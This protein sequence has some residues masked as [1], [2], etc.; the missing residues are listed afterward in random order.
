MKQDFDII[1]SAKNLTLLY[2]TR[3]GIFNRFEHIA[4]NDISFDLY[5]GETIGVLGRNGSGKSSL[6]R[7]LAG[8]IPPTHGKVECDSKI[9]RSLLTLG[10]GFSPHLS[11]RNNA[12]LSAMLQG[13]NKREASAALEEINDFAELGKF[14][15][16]PVKTYSAGMRAR[17][18]FATAMK[19]NVD[20][21]LTDEVLS[22]GDAHF[23][24]KAI[25][26]MLKRLNGDQT[27]V[28]VSHNPEQVDALCDRAVWIED[29][30]IHA[31][32]D[33]AEVVKK[34]HAFIKG[35]G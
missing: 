22:V 31:I 33:T 11:G 13:M 28:L 6:L 24:A 23:K 1:L 20:I 14:F 8:I 2:R 7:I 12:L 10:L 17:L 30:T 25:E 19:A 9:T 32:G 18:G 26:V 15:D 3:S 27:I 35:I 21:L 34:Y 16:Q 5:R 4:L 29:G